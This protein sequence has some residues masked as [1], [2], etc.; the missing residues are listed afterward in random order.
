MWSNSCWNRATLCMRLSNMAR[1]FMTICS[2]MFR[3]R[4]LLRLRFN[5]LRPW[6]YSRCYIKKHARLIF[7]KNLKI[8]LYYCTDIE[9]KM[10]SIG[11]LIYE[12]I[13]VKKKNL[14]KKLWLDY[15]GH[16]LSKDPLG[17][18]LKFSNKFWLSVSFALLPH[19]AYHS[20]WLSFLIFGRDQAPWTQTSKSQALKRLWQSK[21]ELL[22]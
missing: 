18:L 15:R 19:Q 5:N 8:S 1:F 10:I 14:L 21:P 7:N 22:L 16:Q 4:R 2:W 20:K 9:S 12:S 6:Q 17:Y 3:I 11:H 13:K